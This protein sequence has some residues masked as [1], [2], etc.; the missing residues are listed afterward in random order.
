MSNAGRSHH[1]AINVA[2]AIQHDSSF[3]PP[4]WLRNAHLQSTLH[5]MG[6]WRRRVVKRA[7][8]LLA[9][10][11][12]CIVAG[13]DGVRLSAW[14][15]RQPSAAINQPLNGQSND[16]PWVVILHGWLGSADSNYVLSLGALLFGRG[17]NVIR[18]NL[19]D[20]GDSHHLNEGLFHSCLL[21]EVTNAVRALQIRYAASPLSL[22][23]FSLGGNF[24]LRIAAHAPDVNLALK[25]AIAISPAINPAATDAALILAPPIYRQY[26]LAK[27]KQAL[28]LKQHS[29]PHLYDFTELLR[30][31]S[32]TEL[33]AELVQTYSNFDSLSEYY[34]G[35]SLLGERLK[36]LQVPSYIVTSLDDPIIPAV[37]IAQLPRLAALQVITT[38]RGGHCGFFESLR[39]ERWIDHKV[40][41][42]LSSP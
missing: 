15:S 30:S 17:Y 34:Q 23:G 22:I 21:D 33:T 40:L 27:W 5:S 28:K 32:V 13:G 11:E 37:D 20:H 38:S 4:L 24:A 1:V 8:A 7:R 36:N 41:S 16:G 31:P 39:D 26:F 42:L 14:V 12:H 10:A 3:A 35:Y 9:A 6:W 18:L 19:R 29:F 25:R 2:N